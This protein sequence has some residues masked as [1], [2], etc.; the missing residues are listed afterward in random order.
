MSNQIKTLKPKLLHDLNLI[1][2]H[3]ALG[4]IAV[5]SIPCGLA[6]IAVAAQIGHDNREVFG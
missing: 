5:F 6:T 1:L 3:D 4:I 2:A